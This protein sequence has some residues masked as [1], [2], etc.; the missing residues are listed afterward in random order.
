MLIT[1]SLSP[2]H[3]YYFC[4]LEYLSFWYPCMKLQICV[5][6]YIPL[7]YLHLAANHKFPHPDSP[8]STS[9]SRNRDEPESSCAVL[10]IS[11]LRSRLLLR[12][13]RLVCAPTAL[14]DGDITHGNALFLL[15]K[16]DQQKNYIWQQKDRAYSPSSYNLFS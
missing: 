16:I 7:P 2:C 5:S 12:C 9:G 15:M 14:N 13:A 3:C 4:S 10:A 6:P 8:S 1:S 11:C